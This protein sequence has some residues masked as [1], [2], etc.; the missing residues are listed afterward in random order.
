[1]FFSLKP[2]LAPAWN[3][4]YGSL[5]RNHPEKPGAEGSMILR[6]ERCEGFEGLKG[7]EGVKGLKSDMDRMRDS[8]QLDS[9][10]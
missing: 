8:Q 7:L 9:S 10:K 1:M 5:E 4:Q 3:A 2:C 6:F